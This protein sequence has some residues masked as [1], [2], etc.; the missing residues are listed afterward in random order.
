MIK[1]GIGG[2]GVTRKLF[3]SCLAEC[4]PYV[5]CRARTFHFAAYL[6]TQT[7]PPCGAALALQA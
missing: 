7:E 3:T 4:L 1:Y 5:A 6:S 2:P